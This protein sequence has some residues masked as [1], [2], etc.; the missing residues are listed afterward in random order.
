MNNSSLRVSPDRTKERWFSLVC[1]FYPYGPAYC[2][3][4]LFRSF[5]MNEC[6]LVGRQFLGAAGL[7]LIA[8]A[9]LA[10]DD[11]KEFYQYFRESKLVSCDVNNAYFISVVLLACLVDLK[12]CIFSSFFFLH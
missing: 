11:W 2:S 3:T 6:S 4:A 8:Y 5:C 1:N 12:S 10:L 7:G 9:G